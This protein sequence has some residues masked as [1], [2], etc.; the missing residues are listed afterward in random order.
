MT[1]NSDI[2]ARA[3]ELSSQI[4]PRVAL[5][6]LAVLLEEC[7]FGLFRLLG[8]IVGRAWFLVFVISL[9][10]RD[11]FEAGRP[12]RVKQPSPPPTPLQ[13][14]G[15]IPAPDHQGEPGPANTY[16]YSERG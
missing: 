2:M 1:T 5:G 3:G 16:V 15:Y 9:A 12:H 6:K 13:S 10:I 11:G 14:G 4:S 7:F 8:W